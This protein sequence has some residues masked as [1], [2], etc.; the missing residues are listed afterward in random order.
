MIILVRELRR[1]GHPA[2]N[3][4]RDIGEVVSYIVLAVDGRNTFIR[5]MICC[6]NATHNKRHSVAS[7]P[8]G[9]QCDLR[10]KAQL[11]ELHC[12]RPTAREHASCLSRQGVLRTPRPGTLKWRRVLRYA[13]LP[14]RARTDRNCLLATDHGRRAY[15]RSGRYNCGK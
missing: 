15:Q 5:A 10:S 12:P 2:H 6:V 8:R 1:R 11:P 13:P 4:A 14:F 9:N 7:G 3:R